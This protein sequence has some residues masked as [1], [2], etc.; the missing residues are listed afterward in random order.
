V[1]LKKNDIKNGLNKYVGYDTGIDDAMM[2]V[3]LLVLDA[4]ESYRFGEADKE[5]AV[6]LFE[7]DVQYQWA[8]HSKQATRP[9]SYDHLPSCLHI[10]AG[11]EC[12]VTAHSHS[13]L[14]IQQTANPNAFD[15]VFYPPAAIHVQQA[16][17]D[18]QLQGTM[19][20]NIITVFDYSNAPY[21]NMVLGEVINF[22][23]RWSSYPPHFHPQPEVYFYRFDKPQGFGVGFIDDDV[24]K[25]EHNGLGVI[26]KN[27]HPHCAA[28]GYPMYYIWGIRHLDGNP[29]IKTRIDE[30]EHAWM[31][32]EGA[33]IWNGTE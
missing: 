3:A 24:V 15:P 17:T 28:P 7:G 5:V 12:T 13:E 19:R 2:D 1:Y 20:R 23:G 4:G 8:N 14:Y 27:S 11:S 21:S 33:R 30:P 10:G 18:G 32:E 9:N 31:L 25:I 16:G 29:W 26:T 22:A 6:L